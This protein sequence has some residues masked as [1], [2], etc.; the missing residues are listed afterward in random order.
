MSVFSPL[1]PSLPPIPFSTPTRE[2]P[3]CFGFR[4]FRS[5]LA[6]PFVLANHAFA[7][8]S[9]WLSSLDLSKT[10]QDWGKPQADKSVDGGTLSIAGTKFEH[11]LGTHAASLLYVDLKGG[12]TRFNAMVGIDDE[13]TETPI[14]IRFS[15]I[16]DGR[17]LWK[18]GVLKKG[19]AAEKVDVD[20]TGV[21][22]LA[23]A[24]ENEGDSINYD[25]ADWADAKFEVTGEKPATTS[26]PREQKIVLTP[27]PPATPRINGA[28]VFGVRPGHPFLYT[29]PATG[30]R[31]MEFAVDDLPAGLNV[32][33]KT[34]QITG[35]LR[36]RGEYA[37]TLQAKN[38][39]G[40]SQRK[41]KI[42]CGDAIALTPPLGWNSWNC[43]ADAV[44]DAKV[45]SAAD[46][47]VRSGLIQHGWTY[48]NIDDC[49]E[50]RP[51]S[52][53]PLLK[54]E[55]RD[56]NG[57]INTNKKFPDMKALCDYI[58]GKG[59]K[60]GIY[61]S[62]GPTTCAG[63]T[64]SYKHETQD[65]QRYAQWGFD[66]LKY[67][68]CSYGHIAKNETSLSELQKPYHVMRTALDKADRDIVFSLCQYGMGD[69][70]KWGAGRRQ[71]LA[72]HRRHR[73]LL[74]EHGRYR[75]CA[76]RPRK[77]RRARPLE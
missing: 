13:V 67:D 37:V 11:G 10:Q 22:T 27:Q 31:P 6:S 30:E 16:G 75:V 69:V 46:A 20:V 64:A 39:L 38:G 53:D 56:A 3:S 36:D 72:H 34:G 51:G 57:M 12:S 41:F 60:A 4:C 1:R 71:L 2:V 35:V 28:R 18:S 7:A 17:N 23:L 54:G 55:P 70:W 40:Q 59:L 33:A 66:Y 15:V 52:D 19:Q 45:R 68:W 29:I 5:P 76:K 49:W 65:A 63:F 9:V 21:K 26:P 32:D 77:I 74:G 62:P 43:F 50:I 48:I 61:S 14:G 24:V 47:M 42:V 73:R 8:E 44:D 25:H 58:H